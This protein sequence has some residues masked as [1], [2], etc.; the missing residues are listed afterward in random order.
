MGNTTQ[1]RSLLDEAVRW[2]NNVEAG[3]TDGAV[4]LPAPE[5]LWL[6]VLRLEAEALILLD[7]A[8]PT[9]PFRR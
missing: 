3:K 7:P 5:W 4:S 1:A 8:F 6:Q 9:D 2:W